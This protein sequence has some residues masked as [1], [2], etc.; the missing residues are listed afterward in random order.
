MAQIDLLTT[1][2][3]I[4]T[5]FT[6]TGGISLVVLAVAIAGIRAAFEG[7]PRHIGWAIFGGAVAIGA[8][9]IVTTWLGGPATIA[10]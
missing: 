5:F 8:A 1:I 6:T 7:H 2:N 9:W 10:A 4:A 3:N